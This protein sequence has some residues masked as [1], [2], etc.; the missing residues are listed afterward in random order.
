MSEDRRVRKTKRALRVG[1]A[2]LLVEKN[3][4]QITVKELTEKVDIHRST[5]YANFEDIYDLYDHMEDVAIKEI[6]SIVWADDAFEPKIFFELIL[7]YITD[8]RQISKLFFGGSV[9]KSFTNRITELLRESH[10]EYLRKQYNINATDE[11]LEYYWLFVFS[12]SMAIIEKWVTGELTC[13][14]EELME[15]IVN[16]DENFGDFV[17]SQFD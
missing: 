4:Q 1:L 13:S 14:S 11:Q 12:G 9:S 6:S 16:I 2:E 8:N 7:K 17:A 15:M 10:L 3:I 5:F